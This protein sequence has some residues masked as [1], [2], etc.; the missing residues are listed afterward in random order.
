MKRNRK[1]KTSVTK[2]RKGHST[3]MTVSKVPI[4]GKCDSCSFL[5]PKKKNPHTILFKIIESFTVWDSEAK[6]TTDAPT[7]P[8]S[9]DQKGWCGPRG[10]KPVTPQLPAET[11]L[12]GNV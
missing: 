6:G 5:F 11:Y 2:N 10:P 12:Q 4:G 3:E 7:V 9:F 8:G 1:K